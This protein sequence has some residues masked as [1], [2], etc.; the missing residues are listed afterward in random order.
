MA[1]MLS[2]GYIITVALMLF[3]LRDL[4]YKLL[5]A[6]MADYS[7]LFLFLFWGKEGV[8]FLGVGGVGVAPIEN[9]VRKLFKLV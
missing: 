5:D 2:G 6:G 8:S 7:V 9:T 3:L 1:C 4:G